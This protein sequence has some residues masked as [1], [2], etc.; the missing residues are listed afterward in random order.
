MT[1]TNFAAKFK[2]HDEAAEYADLNG[3]T[4]ETTE[5]MEQGVWANFTSPRDLAAEIVAEHDALTKET[6]Q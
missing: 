5:P 3:W 6:A 1:R 2:S 4:L